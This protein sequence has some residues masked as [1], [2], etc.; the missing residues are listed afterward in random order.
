[1]DKVQELNIEQLVTQ[2]CLINV[3]RL[4]VA[5]HMLINSMAHRERILPIC[6]KRTDTKPVRVLQSF[7]RDVL[8]GSSTIRQ[9][10]RRNARH[11]CL[12]TGERSSMN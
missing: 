10:R 4:V 12:T 7:Y 2:K 8:F 1:M 5:M 6:F 11:G 9:E 3:G